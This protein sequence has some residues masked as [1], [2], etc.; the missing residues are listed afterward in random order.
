MP[1]A[2][3]LEA[4]AY[5]DGLV[6]SGDREDAVIFLAHALPRRE[7]IWWACLC[8]WHRLEP[9]PP[10]VADTAL[11]EIVRWV[12][13]PA[14]PQRHAV[15]AVADSVD[16]TPLGFLAQAVKYAGESMSAP[17]LPVVPPPPFLA[18]RMV[19]G[20]LRLEAARADDRADVFHHFLQWGA[21]VAEGKL[22][23]S[24]K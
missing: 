6:A 4:R 23:W 13:E 10:A 9:T 20:A 1:P 2:G 16:D 22:H 7:A 17:G 21:D 8:L 3:D 5:F 12:L 11:G 18:Q 14:E 24:P 15:V 19:A